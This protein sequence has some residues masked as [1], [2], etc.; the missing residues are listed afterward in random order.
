MQRQSATSPME[1]P[2][3]PFVEVVVD[4]SL[5][6]WT[7]GSKDSS[8]ALR[9]NSTRAS[10]KK[11]PCVQRVKSLGNEMEVLRH[12]QNAGDGRESTHQGLDVEVPWTVFDGRQPT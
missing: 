3:M 10:R 4:D 6:R 8:S 7:S 2:Q 5:L 1:C 12:D 11:E 9:L